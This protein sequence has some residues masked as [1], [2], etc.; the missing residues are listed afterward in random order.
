MFR[1]CTKTGESQ[2]L[3]SLPLRLPLFHW[4]L[5]PLLYRPGMQGVMAVGI[6]P[7]TMAEA[8]LPRE[9]LFGHASDVVEEP[10]VRFIQLRQHIGEQGPASVPSSAH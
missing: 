9:V 1:A 5:P 6:E 4:S 3:A 8:R 2:I 7:Q 10:M